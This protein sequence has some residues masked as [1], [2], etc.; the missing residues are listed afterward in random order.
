MRIWVS[1]IAYQ[2]APVL[3]R[4]LESVEAF[5]PNPES[6]PIVVVDGRYSSFEG[7]TKDGNSDDETERL[8]RDFGGVVLSG[9]GP[10]GWPV[11]FVKRTAQF[12]TAVEGDWVLVVDADETLRG[13][14]ARFTEWIKTFEN[15]HARIN[16]KLRDG[17]SSSAG[18]AMHR[19]FR[20]SRGFHVFGAHYIHWR[21][22]RN[23]CSR[24]ETAKVP[25][26]AVHLWHRFDERA[27]AR[28][29]VKE[30]YYAV[31]QRD[32]WRRVNLDGFVLA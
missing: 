9:W 29:S 4:M 12:S 13:D 6:M 20:I 24:K 10:S 3:R 28:H 32:E 27:K 5:R 11:Q 1:C 30:K 22:A 19:L 21:D 26:D 17:D 23:L 16:I 31:C 15:D 25:D 8:T 18:S 7:L 2:D 14:W